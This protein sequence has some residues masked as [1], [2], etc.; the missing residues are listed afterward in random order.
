MKCPTCLSYYKLTA[1]Q[2]R[3]TCNCQG[4]TT[5]LPEEFNAENDTTTETYYYDGT[6]QQPDQALKKDSGKLRMD[7]V[8]WEV[9]TEFA[10]CL[11]FG[12]VT[13]GYE[14]DGWKKVEDWRYDGAAIRHW[15]EY[16][17]G[18]KKDSE[19]GLHPLTHVL[20][21]VAFLLWKELFDNNKSK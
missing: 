4:L 18:V 8:I 15:I 16:K 1:Y 20:T 10:K 9:V 11:T 7:L 17:N 6:S 13:K 12:H 3:Y 14:K 21:N 2:D 19:S 5:V